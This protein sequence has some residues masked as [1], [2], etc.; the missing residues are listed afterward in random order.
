MI[1]LD[2]FRRITALPGFPQQVAQTLQAQAAP[3][4]AQAAA[5]AATAD[6]QLYGAPGSYQ[7][8]PAAPGF[9]AGVVRTHGG[10]INPAETQ[11]SIIRGMEADY[12]RRFAP[13][14]DRL[15]G[16]VMN[17]EA[18]LGLDLARTRRSVSDAAQNVQGQ[19][20]RQ[21]GRFG[22]AR[23]IDPDESTDT[24]SDAVRGARDTRLR[25]QDRRL[26]LMGGASNVSA[27]ARAEYGG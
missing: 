15:V 17:E 12:R 18:G 3:A 2:Y 8:Q 13:I 16:E 27:Q 21:M 10:I 25:V 24:V 20:R 4:T 5:P 11:A 1:D 22:I 9:G 23:R 14:E 26:G 19:R 6:Q 7:V